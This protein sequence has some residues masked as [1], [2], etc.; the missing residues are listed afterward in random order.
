PAAKTGHDA[1]EGQVAANNR[2]PS[3]IDSLGE[4]LNNSFEKDEEGRARL[5]ITLPDEN[6]IQK[7]AEGLRSLLGRFL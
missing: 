5:T 3:L 7:A 4:I 6:V 2:K 1:P